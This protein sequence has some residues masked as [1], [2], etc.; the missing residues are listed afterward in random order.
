M[1]ALRLDDGSIVNSAADLVDCF[2][3]FYSTLFSAEEV[4]RVSQEELLYKLSARLSA[5]QSEVSEGALSVDE[6]F[7]ALK[8]MAHHKAP[9]NDGLPMEFYVK[10]WQVFRG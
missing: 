8:G 1:S 5:D 4:D 10:F 2:A 7:S 6:C 3:N 9:G